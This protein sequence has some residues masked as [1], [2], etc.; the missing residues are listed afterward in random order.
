MVVIWTE[1]ELDVFTGMAAAGVEVVPD[2]TSDMA[3]TVLGLLCFL[4]LWYQLRKYEE[5]ELRKY[6]EEG[7]Y[8][9][10]IQNFLSYKT[11]W[12]SLYRR[13]YKHHHNPLYATYILYITTIYHYHIIYMPLST[14]NTTIIFYTCHY[15]PPTPLSYSIHAT[16]YHQHHYHMPLSYYM[17]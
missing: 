5:E 15:L 14:T 8:F 16:I 1:W 3:M 2:V 12:H 13:Y 9:C 6:E 11:K 7:I 17:H 4:L 10:Y